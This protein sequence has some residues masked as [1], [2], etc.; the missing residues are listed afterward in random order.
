MIAVDAMGGDFAPRAVVRGAYQAAR[1]GVASKLFGDLKVIQ[2]LLYECDHEWQRLPLVIEHCSEVIEMGDTPSRMVLKKKDASL[3]RAMQ[4][5]ADGRADVFFSA[6]NSGAVV[7]AGTLIVGRVPGVLR[8][9]LGNFLPT[10]SGVLFCLDLGATVDCKPEYLEQ[11]ALM[12]SLYVAQTKGIKAPRVALLSNGSE[13]L[14]GSNAV[15]E[16]FMKL[17]GNLE[18]NFVGNL[19]SRDMF[20][21]KAEV[22]VCDGFVG[23]VMLKTMQGTAQVL[24]RWIKDYGQACWWQRMLLY[25]QSSLFRSLKKKLDYAEHGGALLLGLQKPIVIAHGCSHERAVMNALI[26]AQNLIHEATVPLFN[27]ELAAMIKRVKAEKIFEKEHEGISV[28][29]FYHTKDVEKERHL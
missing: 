23:N 16:T 7:V 15:K 27:H 28:D 24:L 19:E 11:F 13:A 21:G 6:G 9:A 5:V 3:V 14:K 29:T 25:M 17:D 18:L 8:P 22:L 10:R 1:K 2:G 20:D 12:G 4:A 26:Y